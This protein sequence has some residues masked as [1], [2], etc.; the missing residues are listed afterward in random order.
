MNVQRQQDYREAAHDDEGEAAH[1][2]EGEA[3]GQVADT[4]EQ[5]E[6][7]A[8]LRVFHGNSLF[9]FEALVFQIT[10]EEE[11]VAPAASSYKDTDHSR[12]PL[13]GLTRGLKF[14]RKH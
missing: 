2:D 1:N 10:D 13:F 11:T 14:K 6:I 12:I 4:D 3:Q 8:V 9:M 7:E 5:N